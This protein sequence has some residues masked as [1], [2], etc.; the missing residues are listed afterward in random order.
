MVRSYQLVF[1]CNDHPARLAGFWAAALD[2][3][4][5]DWPPH[6]RAIVDAHPEWQLTRGVAQDAK[7]RHP[8]L[9]LQLVPEP[10]PTLNRVRF[11]IT[12]PGPNLQGELD[13]LRGLGAVGNEALMTD[14]EGNEF[15]VRLGPENSPRRWSTILIDA[16]DPAAAV[17]FWSR[18]LGFERDGTRCHPPTEWTNPLAPS[19]QFEAARQPKT[20]KNPVHFDVNVTDHADWV[21][22]RDRLVGMGAVVCDPAEFSLDMPNY[23]NNF[24][25][26]RDPDGNEFC[27]QA[28][29]EPHDE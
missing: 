15:T 20:R 12:V 8:R 27:L 21:A 14:P 22:T 25:I 13:R 6:V 19:L 9:F 1:D 3:V 23:G 26:M 2:Y 11:E 16:V 24:A 4:E 10:R 5:P 28:T 18:A 29:S 7:G 17:D